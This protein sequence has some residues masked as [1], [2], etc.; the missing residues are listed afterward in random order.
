MKDLYNL[1]ERTVSPDAGARGFLVVFLTFTVSVLMTLHGRAQT[2]VRQWYA[3]AL[4]LSVHGLM[5]AIVGLSWAFSW[6]FRTGNSRISI[7]AALAGAVVV[8]WGDN[9]SR[10][11]NE[12]RQGLVSWWTGST[13]E[14]GSTFVY[15]IVLGLLAGIS[16]TLA[17]V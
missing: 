8:G 12:V 7:L 17:F 2:G 1:V 5:I 15:G 4:Y 6:L 16:V 11:R 13:S 3:S 14:P 10:E 9:C